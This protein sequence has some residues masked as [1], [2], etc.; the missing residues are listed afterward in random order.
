[1]NNGAITR[2]IDLFKS[3]GISVVLV[4][5]SI[6]DMLSGRESADIDL[7]SPSSPDEIKA[8]ISS[9]PWC[10][11]I[12][13]TG[14]RHGT[15][16]VKFLDTDG[17]Y[18]MLEITQYRIDAFCDGRHAEVRPTRSL[19]EDLARRDFTVNA[20]AF[21][22]KKVLDPFGGQA[23]LEK[24]ILRCVGDPVQRF[25][26]DYLRV[27]RLFR[28]EATLG[29]LVT[30]TSESDYAIWSS[31]LDAALN[32]G[33][34]AQIDLK[35]GDDNFPVKIERVIGE[36]NKVFAD[37]NA[38]CYL[39]L[40]RMW[41]LG[42]MQA[43]FPELN[44]G[45]V[46]CNFLTQHPEHH[47]E[48]DV[49]THIK[50]VV[51]HVE[52]SNLSVGRWLALLHDIAKPITAKIRPEK[53]PWYT[54]YRHDKVGAKMIPEIGRRLRLPKY[55]TDLA[56]KVTRWHLYIYQTPP[57]S[58]AVRKVQLDVGKDNLH[59]LAQLASADHMGRTVSQ[60]IRDY[61]TPV[62]EPLTPILM[63][64]HLQDRGHSPGPKFGVLLKRAFDHQIET[65][66]DSIDRLYEMAVAE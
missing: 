13:D 12:I 45:P 53:G 54:Y 14:L 31:T 65:G 34:A 24:K 60:E 3:A 23:D 43:L 7:A 41:E 27:L 48:G 66:E 33:I 50:L 42:V 58:N 17:E 10:H 63:G 39:F 32:S 1:M 57:T 47:P 61:V 56:A 19:T 38:D 2:I 9:M 29:N 64:R 59:Y 44:A 49:W 35:G 51:Q 4:G 18:I 16:T 5:G 37:K 15:I 52:G 11:G 36:F 25:S 28:F 8:A 30:N 6:R 26:E 21:D 62:A 40:G 22:G 46:P 20:L 55:L